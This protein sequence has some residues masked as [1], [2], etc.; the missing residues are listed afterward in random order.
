MFAHRKFACEKVSSIGLSFCKD[1]K[2][3]ALLNGLK[4]HRKKR[5]LKSIKMKS[6]RKPIAALFAIR[7]YR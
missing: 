6:N 7:E 4:C 2:W 5:E 1:A 3:V